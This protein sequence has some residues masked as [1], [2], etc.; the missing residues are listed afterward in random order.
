[1]DSNKT[2]EVRASQPIEYNVIVEGVKYLVMHNTPN[3][4]QRRSGFKKFLTQKKLIKSVDSHKN[5]KKIVDAINS[6]QNLWD[7]LFTRASIPTS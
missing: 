4:N 2:E 5:A 3:R 7:Q 6:K 1:M